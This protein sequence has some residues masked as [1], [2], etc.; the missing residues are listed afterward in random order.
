MIYKTVEFLQQNVDNLDLEE[1]LIITKDGEPIY[2]VESYSNRQ[3]RDEA[4]ALL[5]MAFIAKK[6]HPKQSSEDVEKF[7]EDL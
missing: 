2:V 4:I 3:K 7:L 6:A 1:P 5:K